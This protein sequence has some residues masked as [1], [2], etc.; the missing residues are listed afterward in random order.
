MIIIG[1]VLHGAEFFIYLLHWRHLVMNIQYLLVCLLRHRST[2]SLTHVWQGEILATNVFVWDDLPH[3]L[4]TN[5]TFMARVLLI[6]VKLRTSLLCENVLLLDHSSI[7]AIRG[8]FSCIASK[9]WAKLL[10][11][12]QIFSDCA[13]EYFL[14]S[15]RESLRSSLLLLVLTQ[16][17]MLLPIL[18]LV[19]HWWIEAHSLNHASSWTSSS[20]A[21]WPFNNWIVCCTVLIMD[22]FD[23]LK[24]IVVN[25]RLI[26]LSY[27]LLFLLVNVNLCSKYCLSI[28]LGLS[29]VSSLVRTYTLE[30][31]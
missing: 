29:W 25:L 17:L 10:L 8:L 19:N 12:N 23:Q 2:V 30:L 5:T 21:S 26:A 7:R 15:S 4:V 16:R 14:S 28:S 18:I 6:R 20:A 27:R 24:Q 13:I 3:L 22:F 9:S 1:T 31:L 11:A